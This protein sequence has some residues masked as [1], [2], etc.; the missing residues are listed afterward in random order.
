MK[1]LLF[2]LGVAVA[3]LASPLAQAKTLAGISSRWFDFANY[4]GYRATSGVTVGSGSI[5]YYSETYDSRYALYTSSSQTA[6][7]EVYLVVNDFTFEGDISWQVYLNSSSSYAAIYKASKDGESW[8]IDDE[9]L[10]YED[11]STVGKTYEMVEATGFTLAEPTYLAFLVSYA[12]VCNLTYTPTEPTESVTISSVTLNQSRIFFDENGDG[13]V[14]FKMTV[15]NGGDYNYDANEIN[16]LL[17]DKT[18]NVDLGEYTLDVALDA[19]STYTVSDASVTFNK[20]LIP[21]GVSVADG[22]QHV[23]TLTEQMTS[24]PYSSDIYTNFYDYPFSVLVQAYG[25]VSANYAQSPVDFGTVKAGGSVSKQVKITNNC[26]Q[27]ITVNGISVV[28]DPNEA[29]PNVSI[30]CDVPFTLNNQT[31]NSDYYKIFNFVFSAPEVGGNADG[32][33]Q[34]NFEGQEP[35]VISYGADVPDPSRFFEDFESYSTGSRPDGAWIYSDNNWSVTTDSYYGSKVL[36]HSSSTASS[37]FITPKIK[38]QGADA[39]NDEYDNISFR[40]ATKSQYSAHGLQISYSYDR[41]NWELLCA[42]TSSSSYYIPS[43]IE[44]AY[45]VA[46]LTS[47]PATYT[48]EIPDGEYWLKFE[49]QYVTIDDLQMPGT[50]E[51]ENDLIISAT[52]WPKKATVNHKFEPS[53][54]VRNIGAAQPASDYAVSLVVNGEVVAEAASV[55]MDAASYYDY[56]FSYTP[57]EAGEIEAYMQWVKDGVVTLK[58]ECQVY[59]VAA[60]SANGSIVVGE[61]SAVKSNSYSTSNAAPIDTYHAYSHSQIVLPASHLAAYGVSGGLKITGIGFQGYNYNSGYGCYAYEGKCDVKVQQVE[62]QP[63]F[64]SSICSYSSFTNLPMD[65]SEVEVIA[66]DA[67]IDIPLSTQQEINE[68]ISIDFSNP[69]VYEEGMDLA[70]D[71]EMGTDAWWASDG[72]TYLSATS[73]VYFVEDSSVSNRAAVGFTDGQYTK[74]TALCRAV[75]VTTFYY[76]LDIYQVYGTVTNAD[77]DPIAGAEISVVSDDVLYTGVTNEDGQ[78]AIDIYQSGLDYTVS[79]QAEG[80]KTYTHSSPVNVGEGDQ[81]VDMLMESESDAIQAISIDQLREQGT[82]V[83]DLQGRRVTRP[84]TGLYIVNGRKTLIK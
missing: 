42:Y 29:H 45:V 37:Y 5:S 24:N 79:A 6:G 1:K 2:A 12:K 71:L 72:N 36:N 63:V 48:V 68:I 59:E 66:D 67:D 51:V 83:Y 55:D 50:V 58:S 33:F 31:S 21:E 7:S 30:D 41:E 53:M 60:E 57:H 16:F 35:M 8:V 47:Q 49:G 56:S 70:F 78:Y 40:C 82:T 15:K 43:F 80:Y 38:A 23:M 54:T 34:L 17:H 76:A 84:A 64:D 62:N 25:G 14:S 11:Y 28:G 10:A 69:L 75:P 73:S 74:Y 61:G 22:L 9:P 13:T 44:S 20:S 3:A 39:E 46:N 4:A 81:Q 26:T 52:E 32:E 65:F 27:Q 77:G 18:A 19:G